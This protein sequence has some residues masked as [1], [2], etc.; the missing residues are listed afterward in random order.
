[1]GVRL[2]NGDEKR[3]ISHSEYLVQSLRDT[4]GFSLFSELLMGGEL[5]E[6]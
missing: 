3:N 4:E 2:R 6:K 1:M 5:K